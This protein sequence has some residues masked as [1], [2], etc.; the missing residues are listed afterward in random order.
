MAA[1]TLLQSNYFATQFFS[2]GN[3]SFSN[4]TTAGTTVVVIL[5]SS[6]DFS[7]ITSVSGCGIASYSQIVSNIG[8]WVVWA[9]AGGTGGTT[10]PVVIDLGGFNTFDV[11]IAEFGNMPTTLSIGP[12]NFTTGSGNTTDSSTITPTSGVPALI[13]AEATMSGVYNGG[14][15]TNGFV[16]FSGVTNTLTDISWLATAS[17]SGSYNTQWTNMFSGGW[18]GLIQ[19]LYGIT[20]PPPPTANYNAPVVTQVGPQIPGTLQYALQNF[21]VY[22]SPP[23]LPNPTPSSTNYPTLVG[24]AIP[25]TLAYLQKNFVAYPSPTPKPNPTPSSTNYPALVGPAI[26]GT[27]G[28]LQKFF[29]PTNSPPPVA[30]SPPTPLKQPGTNTRFTPPIPG[31]LAYLQEFFTPLNSP[32]PFVPPP[33]PPP[34]LTNSPI[35][36]TRATPPIPGTLAYLQEYFVPTPTKQVPAP[37]ARVVQA[38]PSIAFPNIPGAFWQSVFRVSDLNRGNPTPAPPSPPTPPPLVQPNQYPLLARIPDS[39]WA[40][41]TDVRLKRFANNLSAMWNS[42]VRQSILRQTGVEDYTLVL[43]DLLFYYPGNVANWSGTP[44]ATIGEAL[45]RLA[46]WIKQNGGPLP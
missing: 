42:L 11:L 10:G 36:T 21:V 22:P 23:P 28:Y 30:V 26:P 29:V 41:G 12:T 16:D 32:P 15:P 31:T 14:G 33:P 35:Q 18:T 2:T 45:D 37:V 8:G 17:T 24:P 27:L 1:P 38:P 34:S 40:K 4:P 20:S 46:A 7:P 3:F 19:S 43:E 39:A 5:V 9:G 13:L 6:A 44:P 25:G